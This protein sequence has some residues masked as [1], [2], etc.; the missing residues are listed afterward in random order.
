MAA[1]AAL[2]YRQLAERLRHSP[3]NKH[4]ITA[5]HL[6]DE[7]PPLALLQ[8]LSDTCAY[9]DN[10]T[11]STSTASSKWDAVDHQDIND[12]A[13][14]LTDYLTLLKYQP[15]IDDPETIHHYI[16]QGHPPTILAA[17]W[18]LL[19]NEEAHKK[20]AYLSTFLMPVDIAQEYLQDETV[21]ELSDEL[22]A[23]Q[24]EFKNVHK[25]VET[26]RLN[27]NTASTLK[28][29]I[30]QM[31]EEKQQVSVKISRL[32]QKTEQVPKHDLWLQAAKSLRVEQARE[33]DVSE[34]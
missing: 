28:R 24:D 21:A 17:M 13:W 20:R 22:A 25:Q 26:L 10:A 11:S 27:G 23:L 6:A 16:S 7:L 3:F 15:A 33:L 9:I 8:L 34:R 12:V 19:K 14:K 31:E 18:Y 4:N 5:V 32:K 30:Q 1:A 2:D 29:E